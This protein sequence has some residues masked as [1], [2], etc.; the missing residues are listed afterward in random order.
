[1]FRIICLAV[2]YGFGMIQSAFIVGKLFGKIDIREYGSGNA[3]MTNVA[4]VMGAKAGSAVFAVDVIKAILAFV[5][6][7]LIFDG[8]GSFISGTSPLPGLYAGL[9]VILGHD[10]P[11]YL[12]LRGGK[13]AASTLGVILCTN[14]ISCL[15]CYSLGLLTAFISRYISLASLVVF[16]MFPIS[17]IV[18]GA[19]LEAVIVAAV[20]AALGFVQHRNNIK[21]LINHNENKFTIKKKDA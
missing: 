7:S 2:G 5:I 21:R 13:G 1:M 12:K 18:A 8:S 16:I 14:F 4:R 19:E 17:L 9:G 20:I 6:C 10:F 3:G 15:M 11:V